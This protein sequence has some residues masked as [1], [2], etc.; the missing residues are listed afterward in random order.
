MFADKNADISK[1]MTILKRI[2]NR[3]GLP[4]GEPKNTYNSRLAQEVGKWAESK[5]KGYE[6]HKAVFR[7]F[8]VK[9]RHIGEAHVL[10]KIA[11]SVNLNGKDVQKII[12]DRT[13][14]EAVDLDWKRSYELNI[15]EIPTF[16]I[17]HQVLVGAQPYETLRNLLLPN[18]IET[19]SPNPSVPRYHETLL[20]AC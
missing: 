12:Q 17:N 8:F 19:R 16:I 7:A 3:L 5:G 1:M 13:Y 20:S 18:N 6:F 14:R 9:G 2:A 10:A 11:E 15:T 4:F